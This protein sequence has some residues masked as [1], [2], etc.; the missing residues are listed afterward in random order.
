MLL[1]GLFLMVQQQYIDR[2]PHIILIITISV[3]AMTSTK[4]CCVIRQRFFENFG[5]RMITG[6][7]GP[8]SRRYSHS[9]QLLSSLIFHWFFQVTK[10]PVHL[11]MYVEVNEKPVA[12]FIGILLFVFT[13]WKLCWYFGEYHQLNVY[14]SI[15]LISLS[16]KIKN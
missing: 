15:I 1:F 7:V 8:Y 9:S 4:L 14:L 5:W 13:S 3:W 6:D 2:E 11:G 16:S 12:K 10:L